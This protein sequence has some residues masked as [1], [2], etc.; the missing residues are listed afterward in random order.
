MFY[1]I[2]FGC[3]TTVDRDITARRIAVLN[4]AD[5]E[6]LTY[7]QYYINN[8]GPNKGETY[9][10]AKEFGQQ[11]IDNSRQILGPPPM[12]KDGKLS[13]FWLILN[14]VS[15]PSHFPLCSAHRSH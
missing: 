11:F 6:T 5:P 1:D 7:M 9:Q 3:L 10:L 2:L 8:C 13:H 12:Y 15:S 4:R 14:S